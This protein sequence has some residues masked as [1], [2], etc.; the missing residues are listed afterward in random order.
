MSNSVCHNTRLEAVVP[1]VRTPLLSTPTPNGGQHL[2][3]CCLVR[4]ATK[5][6][7]R[8]LSESSSYA[9]LA[10][11]EHQRFLQKKQFHFH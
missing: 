9:S 3:T 11:T 2:A 4:M 1:L 10:T 7:L 8:P 5:V 6:G